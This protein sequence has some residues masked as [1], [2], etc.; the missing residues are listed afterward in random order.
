MSTTSAHAVAVADREPNHRPWWATIDRDDGE[1][2]AWWSLVRERGL[3]EFEIN[4]ILGAD[5]DDYP[6]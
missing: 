4:Y 6:F 1:N 3:T 5:A 2:E